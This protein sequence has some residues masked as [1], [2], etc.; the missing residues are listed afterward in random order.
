MPAPTGW[1]PLRVVLHGGE[2]LLAGP[3]RLA[4]LARTLTAELS[5]VCR[6]TCGSIPT[7]YCRTANS[8]VSAV[9]A[10]HGIKVEYRATGTGWR[11]TGTAGT[12]AGRSSYYQVV[13]AV[14]RLRAAPY[15]R[16]Y[17][18]LLCTI[19]VA[20][21]PAAAY[22][23][24]LTLDPPHL[25]F[26]L[27][28]ATWRRRG[29]AHP[30]R[31]TSTR[32]GSSPSSTAQPAARGGHT[33]PWRAG[34]HTMSGLDFQALA[35]GAGSAAAVNRLIEG[36]R[37]VLRGLLGAVHQAAS[38]MPDVPIIE[39]E[40]FRVAWTLLTTLDNEHPEALDAVLRH[41]YLR[42]WAIRCLEQLNLAPAVNLD[43]QAGRK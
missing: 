2:P 35:S 34:V 28:H 5:G 15:R 21:E 26:L 18:G 38:G 4:A 16:L 40:R 10:A 17:A 36:Q 25:D 33:G 41:P 6:L 30:G 19:D 8:S 27:L 43:S 7:A 39:Q 20:N 22:D 9:F 1:R 12:P 3:E 42:V 37:S 29:R 14:Q 13:A 32:T 24:L 31:R 11:T 23:A